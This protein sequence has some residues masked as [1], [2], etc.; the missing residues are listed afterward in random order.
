MLLGTY[1]SA[2]IRTDVVIAYLAGTAGWCT[3]C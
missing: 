1:S 2:T 3:F